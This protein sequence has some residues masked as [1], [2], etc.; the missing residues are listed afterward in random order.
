MLSARQSTRAVVMGASWGGLDAF[1]QVLGELPEFFPVPVLLVQHQRPGSG[2]RLAEVLNARTPMPVVSPE[3]R[4]RV[5]PGTVYVAPAGYH[6]LIDQQER[7]CFSVGPLVHYS[8]P[9]I[10][11][12][13]YAAG[14]VYGAGL[15][16]VILTGANEDGAAG[17]DYIRRRGGVTLVQ[18]PAEA[19]APVMPQAALDAGAP[20]VLPL[21]QL[22]ARIMEQAFGREA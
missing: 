1:T 11:E 14:H 7:I 16:G 2:G 10:D 18:D 12:L 6:M 20:E 21:K 17:L 9:A 15:I 8:R 19:E 22:G 13:F 4:D 5:R 3:D